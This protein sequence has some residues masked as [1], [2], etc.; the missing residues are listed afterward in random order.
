M[1]GSTDAFTVES[2]VSKA[3]QPMASENDSDCTSSQLLEHHEPAEALQ[4]PTGSS[5]P[6]LSLDEITEKHHILDTGVDRLQ[7]RKAEQPII[8][9]DPLGAKWRLPFENVKTWEAC[10]FLDVY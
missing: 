1:M 6:L 7:E 10:L 9:F 4:I 2:T 8:F 5:D 3:P